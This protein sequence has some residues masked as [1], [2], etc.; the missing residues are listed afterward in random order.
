[1]T[2]QERIR[3]RGV[4]TASYSELPRSAA[5]PHNRLCT[6]TCC[7]RCV[8]LI[9]P[10]PGAHSLSV[11]DAWAFRPNASDQGELHLMTTATASAAPSWSAD[12]ESTAANCGIGQRRVL[13]HRAETRGQ[14]D[15][16]IALV[17]R[18]GCGVRLTPSPTKHVKLNAGRLA[19]PLP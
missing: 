9:R 19:R 7:T 8:R 2:M 10:R 5:S 4:A 1:M 13:S 12:G 17:R 18:T 6:V 15:E 11:W 16:R 14:E 3:E